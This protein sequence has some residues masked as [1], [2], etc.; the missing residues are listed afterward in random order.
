MK[1]EAI[2]LIHDTNPFSDPAVQAAAITFVFCFLG[3]VVCGLWIY[4]SKRLY[5]DSKS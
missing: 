4:R 1:T 2:L 5:E 3:L